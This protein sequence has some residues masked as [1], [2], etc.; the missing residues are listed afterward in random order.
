MNLMKWNKLRY[1]DVPGFWAVPDSQSGRYVDCKRSVLF[2][3]VFIDIGI[4]LIVFLLPREEHTYYFIG[5]LMLCVVTFFTTMIILGLLKLFSVVQGVMGKAED[6]FL[7]KQKCLYCDSDISKR[8]R[9]CPFCRME[10]TPFL[11]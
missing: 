11:K 6:S 8:A 3:N 9:I 5:W 10:I 7:H 2:A 1:T 4:G